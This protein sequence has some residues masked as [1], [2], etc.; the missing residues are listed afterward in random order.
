MRT[1]LLLVA[2]ALPLMSWS[3]SSSN[4]ANTTARVMLLGLFHFDNPGGDAVK[5]KPLDIS[6]PEP[7]KYLLELAQRLASFAPTRVVLEY[8][9][10]RDALMNRRYADFLSGKFDLPKNEIYQIGFRVAMLAKLTRVD[11]FDTSAPAKEVRLWSYLKQEPESEAKL[12]ALISGESTRLQGL[13]DTRTLR[14]IL[15]MSNTTEEDRRNK[16]FYMLLNAVGADG[17]L[18]HGADAAADWWHRNLRMYALIQRYA[19]SG[20]RVLV[21]AGSGHTAVIRDLLRAD[22]ERA[23]EDVLNYF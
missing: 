18:F 14:D 21:I 15:I 10:T 7:Q 22:S 2:I 8:P 20:E 13:H 12:L 3:Q 9:D 11:G 6:Q 19:T 1:L 23:E 5:Y 16:G 4:P 17:R